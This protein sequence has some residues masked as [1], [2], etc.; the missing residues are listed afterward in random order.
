MNGTEAEHIRSFYD[1]HT[2]RFVSFGQ[3]GSDGA[4]HRAVWGPGATNHRQAFRYVEDRIAELMRDLPPSFEAPHLIDLG[5][6]VGASLCY[7]AERLPIRGTGITLSPVQARFAERRIRDAGFADRIRC[8]EE[9]YCDLPA[10]IAPADLAYAIESFVHGST[11]ARFFA[12]CAR[13]VRPGGLLLICDDFRRSAGGPAAARAIERFCRG[14]HINTLLDR[15]ELRSLARAAGF[16]HEGTTDL[17]PY[18]EIGRMRD[19]AA[20]AM[21]ALFGWHP[22]IGRRF[23]YVIGGSALQTCLKHGWIGYDLALFRRL[24]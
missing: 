23:D 5:C 1:R 9:D 10:D 3:R 12:Q 2:S 6:G 11:P 15:D 21:L 13:L 17:S 22:W 14:W 8:I 20:E 24:D 4:L 16:E 18:L 7:L 19:R